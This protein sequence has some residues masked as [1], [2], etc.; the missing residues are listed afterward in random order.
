MTVCDVWMCGWKTVKYICIV[1]QFQLHYHQFS[2]THYL[3]LN[4]YAT[5]MKTALV[6]YVPELQY[7]E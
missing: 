1:S 7:R 2:P 5:N 6:P 3:F 4:L